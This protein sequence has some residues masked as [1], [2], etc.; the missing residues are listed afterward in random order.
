MDEKM[1]QINKWNEYHN[2]IRSRAISRDQN[3]KVT[4]ACKQGTMQR[5]FLS[6]LQKMNKTKT[7]TFSMPE[8]NSWEKLTN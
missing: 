7:K 3:I 8:M 6:Y 4:L 5:A 1:G 2:E